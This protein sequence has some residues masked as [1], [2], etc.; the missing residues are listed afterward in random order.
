[1]TETCGVLVP[2]AEET[3]LWQM[4]EAKFKKHIDVDYVGYMRVDAPATADV[5]YHYMLFFHE[6]GAYMDLPP[7][8]RASGLVK[9]KLTGDCLLVKA[10]VMSGDSVPLTVLEAKEF[11]L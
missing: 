10:D 9:T 3:E 2:A 1:M 5:A 11:A 7:N 8:A 6:E 4:T